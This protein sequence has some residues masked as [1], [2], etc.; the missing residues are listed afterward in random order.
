MSK[1]RIRNVYL[2]GF[3]DNEIKKVK[4]SVE[5]IDNESISYKCCLNRNKADMVVYNTNPM[6]DFK[7]EQIKINNLI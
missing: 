2:H 3:H 1:K 5:L 4:M 6:G 7:G